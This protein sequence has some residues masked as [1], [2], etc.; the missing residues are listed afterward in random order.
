[1]PFLASRSLQIESKLMTN[2]ISQA[3][4]ARTPS[5]PYYMVTT[6]TELLPGYDR[7]MHLDIGIELHSQAHEAGGFLGLEVFTEN[8]ASI[9]ASYWESAEAIEKWRKHSA[10]EHAKALAKKSWF[11][12][13]ITRIAR[14]ESDYGFN[15][16]G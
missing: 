4:V 10:H 12:R 16:D 14:V 13:T 7:Q 15:L 6:T 3:R 9:A 5:P 8:G 1:M 11:G 2:K